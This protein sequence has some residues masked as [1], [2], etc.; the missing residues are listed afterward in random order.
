MYM[1]GQVGPYSLN[2]FDDYEEQIKRKAKKDDK[3]FGD[4]KKKREGTIAGRVSHNEFNTRE[5]IAN[6]NDRQS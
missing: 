3:L 6:H 5:S 2:Y 1:P 4:F